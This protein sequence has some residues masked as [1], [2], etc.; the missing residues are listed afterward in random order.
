MYLQDLPPE[1]F[2]QVTHDLVDVIGIRRAWNL[3]NF[4]N[5]TQ[6]RILVR[7]FDRYLLNRL[8]VPLD[9]DL[10]FL[11]KIKILIEYLFEELGAK[12]RQQ[13]E[14]ITTKF[15]KGISGLSN[16][17]IILGGLRARN[18]PPQPYD[19]VCK[20]WTYQELD[21]HDKASAA[22][23]VEEYHLIPKMFP[24]LG[25][26]RK[27]HFLEFS[28]LNM[29]IAL[30]GETL[31]E[32]ILQYLE[33]LK[34]P[35]L[36]RFFELALNGNTGFNISQGIS[37]AIYK[38]NLHATKTLLGFYSKNMPNMGPKKWA[39][40]VEV[41]VIEGRH[42]PHD[43]LTPILNYKPRGKSHVTRR[44][45][46]SV[47]EFG[48]RAMVNSILAHWNTD[49]NT[50]SILTLPLFIAVR[51]GNH[52]AVSAALDSGADISI[53]VASNIPTLVK[54]DL[55]ALEVAIYRR[56]VDVA[57]VLIDAGSIVPHIS[58]WP[59]HR[60]MY[61]LLRES[62]HKKTNAKLPELWQ[63]KDMSKADM[64]ALEY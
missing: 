21:A 50:G 8:H 61:N 25:N 58:T 13:R 31:L 9:A 49:I 14:E 64:Q 62:V 27:L 29:A 37:R 7:F 36:D 59:T 40:L 11:A 43:F 60:R 35:D 18:D 42:S 63:F 22:F 10:D 26:N 54:R 24:E 32:P 33:S 53:S 23:A 30:S 20:T 46:I 41:A 6:T 16:E 51:S 47:C 44:T 34:L 2:Q 56:K 39:S 55:T 48:S 45:L 4:V 52:H 38:G 17:Y 57:K 5:Y 1:L 12:D 3:R 15:C 28:S 19:Y